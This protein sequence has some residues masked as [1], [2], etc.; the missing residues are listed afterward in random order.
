[1]NE[2][3]EAIKKYLPS[4]W[5]R[6]IATEVGCT[7]ATVNNILGRRKEKNLKSK[8]A[9]SVIDYAIK[10]ADGNRK[11]MEELSNQAQKLG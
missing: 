9:I 2:N 3:F 4:G 10:L 11:A 5:Q 6:K 7:V 8:Y 1:M